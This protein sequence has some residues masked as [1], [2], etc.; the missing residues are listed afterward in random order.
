MAKKEK[1]YQ[2]PDGLFE[3]IRTVNG[4]RVAFRGKTCREVDRKLLA[5]QEKAEGGRTVSEVSCEWQKQKEREGVSN[6]TQT[7]YRL[8][9]DRIEAAIGDKYIKEVKAIDCQRILESMAAQGYKQGTVKLEKTVLVQLFRW[10]VLQ[11]DIDVSPA[12]AVTLPRKLP[13]K[14]RYPLTAEQIKAVTEC[15]DG[16]WWLLGLA[17]LWTGCRRGELLALRY[18]DID[19]KA[20]R[21]TINKKLD[22]STGK[23]VLEDHTKT[24]AGM[25]TIPLLS[26]LGDALPRGRIGLIFHDGE[27][28]YINPSMFVRIWK[29]YQETVGLPSEI[30]PHFF[31]HTF[32]TICY[33]AGSG[34]KETS[35]ILGHASEQITMELYTHLSKKKQDGAAECIERYVAT[36]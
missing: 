11:G 9:C 14:S 19:R 18:E 25:R 15:R 12:A 36:M 5:Y 24:E 1:Y 17:F 28:G 6:W 26:P 3:T 4:K 35:A 27:G 16:D 23:A 22:F 21:I 32:A 8:A 20:R 30:T 33:D 7:S 2:R 29:E 10:A 34:A 31:R 13:K